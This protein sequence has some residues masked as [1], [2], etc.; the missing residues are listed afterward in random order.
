MKLALLAINYACS[1]ITDDVMTW[2]PCITETWF[3]GSAELMGLFLYGLFGAI[4]FRTKLKL[5]VILSV[6]IVLS[7][8][9]AVATQSQIW[10]LLYVISIVLSSGAIAFSLITRFWRD[11]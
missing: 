7:L 6:N 4:V 2:L 11:Y 1:Q 9:L 3:F 8:I 5:P 10:G